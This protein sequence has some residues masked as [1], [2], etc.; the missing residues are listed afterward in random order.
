MVVR[1][2]GVADASSRRATESDWA[3]FEVG[4]ADSAG[5][6]GRYWD[7]DCDCDCDSCDCC[8]AGRDS[9]RDRDCGCDAD[10]LAEYE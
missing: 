7:W 3:G 9:D 2:E 4:I 6:F 5:I 1:A 8:D 10:S